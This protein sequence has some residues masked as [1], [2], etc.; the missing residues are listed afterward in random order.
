MKRGVVLLNMGGASSLDEV[1]LFLKN[2]FNDPLILRIP[3][4]PLRRMLAAFITWRRAEGSK[5]NY[6]LIGGRSP[7]L[8]H[9]RQ[10]A[11]K[12]EAGSDFRCF[13]AMRYTPPF[14]D[15]AA[16][17]I[18][19][20]DLDE[21]ILLPLYPQYSST[22]TQSSIE[23]F[24]AAL[25]HAGFDRPV[26]L[27]ERF[28]DHPT[29]NHAIV[30]QIEQAL[31]GEHPKDYALIFSAHGLPQ[32][33]IDSGDPYQKECEAHVAILKKQLALASLNFGRTEL[34]YQ[35]KV[36]PMKWIEPSL[37]EMLE[38]LLEAGYKRVLIY[39]LAFTID[40]LE[41]DFE[42]A[43]EYREAAMKMG[44]EAY[45]VARCP[46]DSDRFARALIE[47]SSAAE[48]KGPYA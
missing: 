13:I 37:D 39:P 15:E 27:I 2:M 44:F 43:I 30:E 3:F 8:A 26:R 4:A 29:F 14:A 10:L 47:L 33:V 48:L 9:T 17:E 41:T 24:G 11:K 16:R 18:A 42:L 1:P 34:A 32:S 25:K 7:L 40:N 28:Y 23:D 21:L 35:S 19:Q 12:I 38:T 45:R 36:G 6:R 22:T 20:S 5:S 31:E 46:N